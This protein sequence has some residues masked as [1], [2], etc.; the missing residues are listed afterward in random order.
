MCM[1]VQW[2]EVL[3]FTLIRLHKSEDV[4]SAKDDARAGLECRSVSNERTVDVAHCVVTRRQRH[5]VYIIIIYLIYQS[6]A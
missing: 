1:T 2:L 4:S 6:T 5:R 3:S